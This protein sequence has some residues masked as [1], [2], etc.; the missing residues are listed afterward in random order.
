MRLVFAH[1]DENYLRGLRALFKYTPVCSSRVVPVVMAVRAHALYASLRKTHPSPV[2]LLLSTA[3]GT[4][5]ACT[6]ANVIH[7]APSASALQH[8]LTSLM[9]RGEHDVVVVQPLAD[10]RALYAAVVHAMDASPTK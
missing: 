6:D 3:P 8:T 4:T 9:Q 7:Y 5:P 2:A 10:V 1:V